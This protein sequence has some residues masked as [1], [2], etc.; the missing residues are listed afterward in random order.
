MIDD[1]WLCFSGLTCTEPEAK[2][3][4]GGGGGPDSPPPGKS[5]KAIGFL[6]NTGTDKMENRKCTKPEFNVPPP[7][8]QSFSGGP[9]MAPF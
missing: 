7:F 4:G 1:D 8:K 3:I 6:I 9:M 2:G 5:H